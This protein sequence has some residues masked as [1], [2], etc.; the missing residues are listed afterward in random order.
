MPGRF[1]FQPLKEV[2]PFDA[3]VT[4]AAEATMF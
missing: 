3:F 4:A 1:A 2:V